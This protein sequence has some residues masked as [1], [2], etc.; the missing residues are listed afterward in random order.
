[1]ELGPD[2]D[3]ATLVIECAQRT[4]AEDAAAFWTKAD[5]ID[6]SGKAIRDV[7]D[8][9]FLNSGKVESQAQDLAASL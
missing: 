4:D 5:L 3:V 9:E 1:M 8:V 7:E 2:K 6:R